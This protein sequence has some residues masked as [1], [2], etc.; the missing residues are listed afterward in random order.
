MISVVVPVYNVEK[1]LSRCIESIINQTYWDFEILLIDDGSTDSSA[2][3]CKM[4]L[5]KDKRIKYIRKINGGLS[6]A[7]NVGLVLSE[8]EYITFIDSD[9]FIHD[10]YLEYLYTVLVEH[11]ADIVCCN[12]IETSMDEIVLEEKEENII[13]MSGHEACARVVS[14]LAPMLTS[15]WGSL[16][17]KSCIENI[18]FPFR[19]LHEDVATTY[20]YYL[21]SQKVIYSDRRLYAY[22]QR[23]DSIMHEV[24]L[25]KIEDEL[26]AMSE[27]A[28][29]L[30]RMG[31]KH[32]SQMSWDF[33][34]GF[35]VRD[36]LAQKGNRKIWKKYG[37]IYIE[38]TTRIKSKLKIWLLIYFPCTSKI[39]GKLRK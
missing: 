21:N 14:D 4:Y 10:S 18:R 29:C 16:Y 11:N 36:I 7:R 24:N 22:Y 39:Y 28:G 35:L 38:N 25:K 32:L 23:P 17:K 27:R 12:H 26:W 8:G 15:A 30:E 3:I 31:E 19:R 33:M 9:D 2:E 13:C 37:K 1:Y 34:S 6:D 5:A 20:K